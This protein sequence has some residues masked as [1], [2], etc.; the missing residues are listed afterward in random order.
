MVKDRGNPSVPFSG[1]PQWSYSRCQPS[2]WN[3][4]SAPSLT[5]MGELSAT[6]QLH[7][8]ISIFPHFSFALHLC[9]H[10]D[11]PERLIADFT[12]NYD[13]P[14][15]SI[16]Q[17]ASQAFVE[18]RTFSFSLKHGIFFP[19][20]RQDVFQYLHILLVLPPTHSDKHIL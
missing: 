14:L 17:N 13:Y 20:N 10:R 6:V 16:L 4:V 7:L 2:I 12:G 3:S 15:L 18:G 19:F 9:C 1:E 5:N 8:Y 11:D